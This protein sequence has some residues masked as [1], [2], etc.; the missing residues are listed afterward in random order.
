MTARWHV[1]RWSLETGG[2]PTTRAGLWL[3]LELDGIS[4]EGEACPMPNYNGDS[5]ARAADSVTT[6]IAL[7]SEWTD[8][9]HGGDLDA[10]E[11]LVTTAANESPSAA[12]GLEM[13]ALDWLGRRSGRPVASLLAERSGAA[14]RRVAMNAVLPPG[15]D[16]WEDAARAAAARGLRAVKIKVGRAP[17]VD[18]VAGVAAVRRVVG[19]AIEI[20]LDANGAWTADEAHH[21]LERFA[22]SNIAFCEQPVPP[23]DLVDFLERAPAVPIAADESCGHPKERQE[24]LETAPDALAAW[25]LK[26]MAL[27]GALVCLRLAALARPRSV[28]VTH[29][30][31]GPLGAAYAAE[32]A[33]ALPV[34]P[35]ACGLDVHAG[36]RA[37]RVLPRQLGRND[38]G[39]ALLP[40]LGLSLAAR[41]P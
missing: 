7:G 25:V 11:A 21:A 8:A 4:G 34:Q 35:L 28:L 12:C 15:V 6:S 3:Q 27:G 14:L 33:A 5:L 32:L 1:E 18:E 30:L 22:P 41:L 36:L 24:L 9:L 26:P 19:A 23:G 37:W 2:W 20:R 17:L 16:A 13:A 39:S 29:L 10:I 31:D 38:A 40:G